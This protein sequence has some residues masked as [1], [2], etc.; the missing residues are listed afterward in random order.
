MDSQHSVTIAEFEKNK[1]ERLR[2]SLESFPPGKPWAISI[3]A[4][5]Q[6]Q[7]GSWLPSKKGITLRLAHYQPLLNALTALKV[8]V[9]RDPATYNR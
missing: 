5:Y 3:R 4:L 9:D 6:S 8:E 1:T 7:D 2:I